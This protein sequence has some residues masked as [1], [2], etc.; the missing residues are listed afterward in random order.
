MSTVVERGGGEQGRRVSQGRGRDA[1]L[2]GVSP[3][4]EY[5]LSIQHQ[6]I[7]F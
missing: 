7:H 2:A 4:C 6:N 3:S 1:K 5:K